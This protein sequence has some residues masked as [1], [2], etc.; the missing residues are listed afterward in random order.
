[1][2]SRE[3]IL[4]FALALM[5][6]NRGILKFSSG[7]GACVV[8]RTLPRK[9]P[10]TIIAIFTGFASMVFVFLTPHPM[11]KVCHDKFFLTSEFVVKPPATLSFIECKL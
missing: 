3:V 4:F 5:G 8:Q 10:N 11:R 2:D 1:V 7:G 6:E 9:K